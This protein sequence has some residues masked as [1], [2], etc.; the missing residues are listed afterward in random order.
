V[1]WLGLHL[2]TA[3]TYLFFYY[4]HIAKLR[5][6]TIAMQARYGWLSQFY[7]HSGKDTLLAFTVG[8][9]L[10]VFRYVFSSN[11][12]AIPLFIAFLLG[13]C[14]LLDPMTQ[15]PAKTPTRPLALLLV[16]P[17]VANYG[18]AL[19]GLFPY[20]GRWEEAY[21]ALFVIAGTSYA[22]ARL[23]RKNISPGLIATA[24][25]LLIIN[26]RPVPV[27]I[28]HPENQARAWMT[29]ALGA[30]RHNVPAGSLIFSDYQ[31]TLALH[32][33]LCPEQP[34][35]FGAFEDSINEFPCGD[36]RVVSN[37]RSHQIS[38]VENFSRDVERVAIR[39]RLEPGQRL[40]VFHAS[41]EPDLVQSLEKRYPILRFPVAYPFGANVVVF[42]LTIPSAESVPGR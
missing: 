29:G 19:A 34:F 6:S 1:T 10:M 31:S 7:F 4:T 22:L 8:N 23:G 40:W 24:A 16:L 13:L 2:A 20:G 35:P 18:G 38:V 21:L 17:F 27:T 25:V 14:L 3:A 39:Y 32:Y 42:Q 15:P 28:I 36:Y 41:G 26:L 9:T 5:T 33:Y 12:A 11:L 30:I 37:S